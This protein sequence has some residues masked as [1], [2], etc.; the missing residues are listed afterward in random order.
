MKRTINYQDYLLESLQDPKEA[1]GYLNAA[2]DENDIELFLIA[3]KNV[4][5]AQGGVAKLSEKVHKSRTSL[6]KTLS[7]KGNPYLKNTNELLHAIG[8]QLSVTS[9]I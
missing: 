1:A 3:L 9:C 8:L 6:Y 5:K 4:V 7:K 2:L